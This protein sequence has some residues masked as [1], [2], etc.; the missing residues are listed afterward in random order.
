LALATRTTIQTVSHALVSENI[1]PIAR[2]LEKR[3]GDLWPGTPD[4]E[5]TE[6][7]NLQLRRHGHPVNFA[8]FSGGEKTMAVVLLRFLAIQMTTRSSFIC[9]DEP[10]EH[11]DSKNRRMLA[12]LLVEA[13]QHG[14]M[15]QVIVTTYEE[16]IARALGASMVGT[17][18]AN[19]KYVTATD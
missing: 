12:R 7:G 17:P 2:Q 14:P 3:W 18:R 4:L 8:N 9:F 19:V 11:L 16:S 10:L 5:L 13:T 15:K 1:E 6:E